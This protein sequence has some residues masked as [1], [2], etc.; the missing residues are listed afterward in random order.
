LA[1]P[2]STDVPK[3]DAAFIVKALT[4]APEAISRRP[5]SCV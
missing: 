2:V 5:L 3:E 4:A 1:A